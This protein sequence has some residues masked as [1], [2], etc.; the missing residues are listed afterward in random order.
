MAVFCSCSKDK[1]ETAERVSINYDQKSDGFVAGEDHQPYFYDHSGFTTD[2]NTYYFINESNGCVYFYEGDAEKAMPLCNR[3]NCAH[4]NEECNAYFPDTASDLLACYKGYLYIIG[5]NDEVNGAYLFRMSMD[6]TNRAKLCKLYDIPDSTFMYNCEAI[7][8]RGYLYYRIPDYNLSEHDCIM[9]RVALEPDA[10][11]EAVFK[12]STIGGNIQ[13]MT[14]YGNNIYFEVQAYAD[15]SGNDLHG[16]LYQ[17]NIHDGTTSVVKS[18]LMRDYCV[19]DN[20]VYYDNG[21][22]IMKFNISTNEEEKIYSA[23]APVYFSC[24]GEHLFIDN[25]CGLWL[26]G[27]DNADASERHIFITDLNGE[28]V[29]SI[30]LPDPHAECVFGDSKKMFVIVAEMDYT[31]RC[32]D[33]SDISSIADTVKTIIGE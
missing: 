20:F 24:D 13:S 8:H 6:G 22:D 28:Q 32:Y 25:W 15:L 23:G 26:A 2:G 1:E 21:T 9:Y 31:V 33:K 5:Y 17:Y 7:V 12:Q 4:D 19:W 27:E 16:D 18:D 30:D 14:A 11:P 29:G 10:K 3:I